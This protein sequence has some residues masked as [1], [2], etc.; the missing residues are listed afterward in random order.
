MASVP[1]V[2]IY[3]LEHFPG[4]AG[5]R[6]QRLYK[7]IA[8]AFDPFTDCRA[9]YI[10]RTLGSGFCLWQEPGEKRERRETVRWLPGRRGVR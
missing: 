5:D 1:L 9:A 8:S 2:C 4:K 10:R 6:Q 7:N 3:W